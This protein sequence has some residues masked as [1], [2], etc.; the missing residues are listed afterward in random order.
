MIFVSLVV[1]ALG[2]IGSANSATLSWTDNSTNELGFEVER[3]AGL[4]VATS[5]WTK[6]GES[7]ANV[8]SFIDPTTIPN[9]GTAWAYRVRAFNNSMLDGSGVRQLS[10]Y[11]NCAEISYPL[12]VPA[13]PSQLQVSP[14][15]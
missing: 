2:F 12:V 7:L 3:K 11:S 14:G 9:S 10:G 1:F 5:A 8:R 13:D 6:I 15:Q 4:C